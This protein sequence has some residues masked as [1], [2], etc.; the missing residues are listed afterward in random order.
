MNAHAKAWLLVPQGLPS[1]AVADHEV[2][3]YLSVVEARPVP[4]A[5]LHVGAVIFWRDCIVPL[6][7]FAVLAGQTS[8]ATSKT[9]LLGYQ[10][11]PATPLSYIAI[12]LRESPTRVVVDDETACPLPESNAEFWQHLAKA[13]FF[14]AGVAIPI[15]D[16]A[17][18]CSAGFRDFLN[19]YA[20]TSWSLEENLGSG[21]AT[22]SQ[23]VE[24]GCNSVTESI[25]TPNTA[26]II[27]FD[28]S[29][30]NSESEFAAMDDDWIDASDEDS[31]DN[32]LDEDFDE[33]DSDDEW[34][35]EDDENFDDV[36]EDEFDDEDDTWGDDLEDDS[37]DGGSDSDWDDEEDFASLEDDDEDDDLEDFDD[38]LDEDD[39]D[40]DS[41][42]SY[43]DD[44]KDLAA[45]Q[46]SKRVRAV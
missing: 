34:M 3:E 22:V 41:D 1:L 37:V 30:G 42:D 45:A 29:N 5:P 26:Q 10:R 13:C 24:Q 16:I 4:M 44:E 43:D 21:L 20:F 19:N 25:E 38:G 33:E 11:E 7:N 36:D 35:N 14:H 23:G 12:A 2:I 40:L 46:S 31:D 9:V 27:D 39:D 8:A 15:I 28:Q 17:V 18:L 6:M 32:W